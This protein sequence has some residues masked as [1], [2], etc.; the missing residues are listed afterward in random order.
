MLI[1]TEKSIIELGGITMKKVLLLITSLFLIGCQTTDKAVEEQRQ[2]SEDVEYVEKIEDDP[3]VEEEEQTQDEVEIEDIPNDEDNSD[4][5]DSMIDSQPEEDS[6]RSEQSDHD[7]ESYSPEDA[8][9]LVFE[10]I[11]EEAVEIELSYSFDGEDANGD[12]R[13]QVF[14]LVGDGDGQSHTATY[15]W[16]LVNPE[17][18]EITDMIG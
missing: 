4:I 12:Y 11:K 9:M 14:E 1:L 16:Y 17:T 2:T 6:D 15:G 18:G 8:I 5:S 10:Y 7:D 13:I 3:V